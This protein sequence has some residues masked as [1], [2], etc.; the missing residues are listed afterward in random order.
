MIQKY[1]LPVFSSQ[2]AI[3]AVSVGAG[4]ADEV[5]KAFVEM[6]FEVERK[7]LPKLGEEDEEGSG[8]E[9]ESMDGSE[10]GSE[11]DSDDEMGKH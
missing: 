4:K 11:A 5:E 3:G 6:G 7:E 8:D 2:T 1:F 10:D 9:D